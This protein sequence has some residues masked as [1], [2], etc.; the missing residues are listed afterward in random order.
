MLFPSKASEMSIDSKKP[1]L[2]SEKT[3]RVVACFLIHGFFLRI[4][5]LQL[6]PPGFVAPGLW[7]SL[8]GDRQHEASCEPEFALGVNHRTL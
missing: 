3:H 1:G 8:R 2:D 6:R 5:N 7:A 4:S